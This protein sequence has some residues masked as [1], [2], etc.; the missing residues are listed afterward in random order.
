MRSAG[1][2]LLIDVGREPL[3]VLASRIQRLGFRTIRAKTPDEAQLLLRDH[4][5]SFGAAIVPPDLPVPDRKRALDAF[6]Q[7]TRHGELPL[8]AAGSRPDRAL[9]QELRRDGIETAIFEPIDAH[10][11]RFQLNQAIASVRPLRRD[12]SSLRAPANWELSWRRRG[13][14]HEARVYT[15]S[16]RGAFLSTRSPSLRGVSF[17]L[18]VPV[19]GHTVRTRAEVV[20]TNVPGNLLR[21][22]LPAGMGIRFDGLGDRS[23]AAIE[24]YA[25]S[26]LARLSL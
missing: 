21:P 20:M 1:T 22:N 5:F 6:R 2:V 7:L 13:R 17:K 19:D 12:R 18:E 11:L 15:I 3:A 9:R 26:R 4:R 25:R 14:R 8:L 23:S 16:A 10:G 24:L